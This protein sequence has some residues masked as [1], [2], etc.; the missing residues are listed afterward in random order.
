MWLELRPG[1]PYYFPAAFLSGDGS[2]PATV[3]GA[4]ETWSDDSDATH[5]TLDEWNG[6]GTGEYTTTM[7]ADFPPWPAGRILNVQVSVRGQ[8]LQG[9]GPMSVL[10]LSDASLD[11]AMATEF[12]VKTNVFN[13]AGPTW[14][15]GEDWWIHDGG[16]LTLPRLRL[17]AWTNFPSHADPTPLFRVYEAKLLVEVASTGL[18]P[19]RQDLCRDD[20]RVWPRSSMQTTNRHIGG[21]Y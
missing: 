7:S 20:H 14:Y 11:A 3:T 5:V 13:T 19:L 12:N 17:T 16:E 8:R 10:A 1:A 9:S 4:G 18:P 2:S 6:G 15:G 21:Y